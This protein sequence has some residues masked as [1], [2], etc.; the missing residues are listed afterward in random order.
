[1]RP[2]TSPIA[3]WTGLVVLY[4][5]WG[6]T[7]LGMKLAT[8]TMS[9]VMLGALRFLPAGILLAGVIA[10]RERSRLRRPTPRGWL[11][12][13]IVGVLLLVGGTGLVAWAQQT[14]PTGIAAL[15]VGL[16]PM[17]LA[18]FGRVLLGDRIPRLAAVGI[19]V[20]IV[21]IAVLAWPV[22]GVGRLDPAGFAALLVAPVCWSLGTLYAA[23]RAVLPRPALFA[24]G[25]QM[26]AGGIAFLV[27]AA[28]TG[29][30]AAFDASSVSATSWLGIAY[31]I[32]VGSLVGY[33]TFAW[34]LTVAPLPRV[35]TYAYVNPVVAVV[36]G[37]VVLGE[38][39]TA[40]TLLAGTI[41][42]AAVAMIITARARTAS[43]TPARV[44][45]MPAT[46][47]APSG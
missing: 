2:V 14:V 25:L 31:L 1:M 46:K 35:A 13:G 29:E 26:I 21:G 4:L 37:S 40:R 20:G 39:L 15:M 19:A 16:V 28:V 5:V 17:W 12:T 47:P 7:Y 9:P 32:A 33:T 8:E 38:A 36:L 43:S 18:V 24:S 6:S 30:L 10:I 11:D 22:S 23:R 42:V 44:D 3:V 34:L 45:A 41:I 27:L